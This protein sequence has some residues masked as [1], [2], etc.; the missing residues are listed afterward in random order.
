MWKYVVPYRIGMSHDASG[1]MWYF[2]VTVDMLFIFDIVLNFRTGYQER[3]GS[4]LPQMNPKKVAKNYA[5]S[6][7][8]L[9]CVSGI[10][11]DLLDVGGD[12]K[13]LKLLKSARLIKLLKIVRL[14]KVRGPLLL[15]SSDSAELLT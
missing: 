2:E 8:F 14:L 15:S 13:S 1:A 5:Q 11:F 7:L 9:D 6:W 4:Q 10:P 3:D 12:T